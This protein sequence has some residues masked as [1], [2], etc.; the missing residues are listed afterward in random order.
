MADKVITIPYNPHDGQREF[1]QSQARFRVLACGRRWG[2]DRASINELIRL[3]WMLSE[4]RQGE[5]TLV[6]PVHAWIVAPNYPLTRQCWLEL[7]H[8]TPPEILA[9]KPHETEKRMEWKTGAVIECKS[10]DQYD[11]LKSVGL[12]VLLMTEAAMVKD[13]AWYESLRPTLSSPG[14]LGKAILNSTPKG[15]NWFWQVY[16][17][18]FNPEEK[19]W[20]GWNFPSWT[21]PYIRDIEIE[22]ARRQMPELLFRQEYGAEF[23]EDGTCVFRN[24]DACEKGEYQGPTPRG[25]YV[26]GVDIA[27]R[28]DFTVIVVMDAVSR[29]VVGFDR[30]GEM[31]FVLQKERIKALAGKYRATVWLDSTGMGEPIFDELAG[32]GLK[33]IPFRFNNATK[34]AVI[35]NLSIGF[36]Q[37]QL[38]F[39]PNDLLKNELKA[40]ES[41]ALPSG[42]F[43]YSAPHGGFDD[44]VIGLGLAYWAATQYQPTF[45]YIDDPIVP[46]AFIW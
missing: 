20:A 23:L 36:E 9:T 38:S 8:F 2:K 26:M 41:Q 21:N 22:Q 15:R 46:G 4:E 1:H 31:S 45:M 25:I 39:P 32:E 43:T 11:S 33:I 34:Q 40:Y 35:D 7:K 18:S 6:P 19:E 29:H 16:R 17:R 12:D 30:F 42:R 27:R 3:V 10:A 5:K 37:E 14:R 13:D 24:I 44:C 28:T